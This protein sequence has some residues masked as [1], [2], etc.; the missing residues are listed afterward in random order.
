MKKIICL[1]VLGILIVLILSGCKCNHSIKFNA[2]C[3]LPQVCEK[4]GEKFGEI[5]PNG[6]EWIDATCT[7][8]K[9]CNLCNKTEGEKLEHIWIE[10]TCTTPKKCK[11]CGLTE[12][13]E[14]GHSWVE[15]TYENPKTCSICNITEGSPKERP[16][17]SVT[18][19]PS[20]PYSFNQYYSSGKLWRTVRITNIRTEF[21][22]SYNGKYRIKLY[23]SGEKTYDED[24]PNYSASCSIGIKV[25]DE[26]GYVVATD[27]YFTEDL[28]VGDKFKDDEST[29][30]K[31]LPRGNYKIELIG[32]K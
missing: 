5:N 32:T 10:A 26:N 2:T 3:A 14:L 27:D 7:L 30:F 25:Y 1:S 21:E 11:L 9:T 23:F 16:P 28:Q 20:V 12:G 22:E 13:G 18:I 24:G 19:S 31:D 15:A 29:I 8:P 17:M 6:H 4:C